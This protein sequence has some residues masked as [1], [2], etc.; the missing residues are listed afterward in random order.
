[1]RIWSR[2]RK[3]KTE[4]KDTVPWD[5]TTTVGHAFWLATQAN[6]LGHWGAP[7][8]S[9]STPSLPPTSF[10]PLCL[11]P[12]QIRK[13]ETGSMEMHHPVLGPIFSQLSQ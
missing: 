5:A 3:W 8:L 6:V 9:P 13:V 11:L 10:L 2:E 12:F 7:L 4:N 1:M